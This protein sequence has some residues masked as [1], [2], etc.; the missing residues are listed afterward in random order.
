MCVYHGE[1][2]DVISA[3]GEYQDR[4]L[5]MANLGNSFAIHRVVS[6]VVLLLNVYI[7]YELWQTAQVRLR[8]LVSATLA[9]IA[10]EIVA[11]IVLAN[12][13]LPPAV[14]PVHLVLATV[15]FGIQFLTVLAVARARKTWETVGPTDAA[16][17]VV[18]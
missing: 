13:A 18:A 3:A 11:G 1:Q 2:I 9:T 16:R 6:A 4:R 8:R 7:A 17:R 15:L 5:W 14:Q 12:W 10:L